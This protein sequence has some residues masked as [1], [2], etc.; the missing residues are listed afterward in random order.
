MPPTRPTNRPTNPKNQ[1]FSAIFGNFT[2][3]CSWMAVS[4]SVLQKQG[5]FLQRPTSFLQ[6][7]KP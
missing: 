4:Y 7:Y 1:A 6:S 5:C 2:Q 3:K